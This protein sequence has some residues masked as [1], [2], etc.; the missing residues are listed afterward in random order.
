MHV[1]DNPQVHVVAAVLFDAL[2]NVLLAQRPA[3][4]HMA[5]YWEFP[6]GKLEPS[7]A[8]LDALRRELIE[9]I[10]V[11]IRAAEPLIRIPWNYP[12][13]RILL[14]VYLV[15]DF[16]GV[17]HSRE[18]QA[19]QWTPVNAL[20]PAQMPAADHPVVNAL[21]LPHEYLVTPE[22]DTDTERFLRRMKH[23]LDG[24]V[25]LVQLRAKHFPEEDLRSL[26]SRALALTRTAG[27]QLLINARADLAIAL[28]LDG[29]HVTAEQLCALKERPVPVRQWFAASCHNRKEIELAQRLGVDF[30]T[31]GAVNATPTHPS[32]TPLD[33]YRFAQLCESSVVPVYA[34]GGV[35]R[36][37]LET[38][39]CSG[40]QGI[41]A[42]RGLW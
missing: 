39:R 2:G 27:A 7:E 23:A 19:L 4:K 10:G 16:D 38:A 18:G 35:S 6:G 3:G 25:R 34:L 20:D 15:R 17:P 33:W 37:D 12:E 13:K 26:A 21:R 1:V 42:I 9:E 29:V 8:P 40:A 11:R 31:V 14:D 30:I 28:D 32:A 22:P 41:A 5:G 36:K 24:G